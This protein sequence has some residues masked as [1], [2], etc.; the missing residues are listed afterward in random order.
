M[1]AQLLALAT[2]LISTQ[3]PSSRAGDAEHGEQVSSRCVACHGPSGVTDN[4]TIPNIAGQNGAYLFAQLQHFHDGS[5]TN[6][7]IVH[8]PGSHARG[9]R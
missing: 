7:L 9:A 4:P 6:P 1:N 3:A 5:R 2:L 8:R